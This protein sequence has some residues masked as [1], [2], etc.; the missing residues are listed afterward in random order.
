MRTLLW[1]SKG[2]AHARPPATSI[3]S[4]S[5][6][7]G[8]TLARRKSGWADRD[9]PGEDDCRRDRAPPGH[10]PPVGLLDA[11]AGNHPCRPPRAAVDR[12]PARLRKLGAYL[13][14]TDWNTDWTSGE[15]RAIDD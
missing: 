12:H 3:E 7:C 13:R 6:P 10:R 9:H 4:V 1:V 2:H 14:N 11:G 5:D 8:A 15:N